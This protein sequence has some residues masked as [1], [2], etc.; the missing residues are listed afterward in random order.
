MSDVER[1]YRQLV[2]TLRANY[3]QYLTQPF[4]VGELYQTILPYRLHRRELGLETNQDYEVTLLELLTGAH[5]Y[6]VVDERMRDVLKAELS[7]PNPDTA[8]IRDF[9]S[10]QVTLSPEPVN[11][12]LLPEP[13]RSSSPTAPRGAVSAPAR[14]SD[15]RTGSSV[16]APAAESVRRTAKPILVPES[17]ESCSFC[18]GT[19]PAG[20]KISFCPHCGQDQTLV[21][22]PACGGEMERGWKF[23]VTCG[24]D[25]STS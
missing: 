24:R 20:R 11:D 25:A 9:A 8:R 14:A 7:S 13:V 17:G 16:G 21:H 19:L 23:C 22:C 18:K 15:A 2:R 1:M 12:T 6:L 3:P 4:D 5:G 10:A